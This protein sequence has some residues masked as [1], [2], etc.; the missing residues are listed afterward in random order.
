MA[1]R[2]GTCGFVY[3][4]WRGPFYPP[5]L[6]QSRWL[7]WYATRFPAVEIDASFYRLPSARAIAAWRRLTV[8]HPAFRFALKGSRLITHAR[9]LSG[10]DAAVETF[11]GRVRPLGPALAFVLWQLPPDMEADLPRLARFLDR[12]PPDLRY[13]V[14]FRHPSW[15]GPETFEVL[16]EHRVALCWVSSQRM[17]ADTTITSDFVAL[18]FH[19]LGGGFAHDYSDDE[20]RPWADALRRAAADGLDGYAFFN[21][22]GGARAPADAVQLIG[23]LGEAAAGSVVGGERLGR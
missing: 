9:R 7:A 10:A 20:L 4:H 21:N 8:E 12:L 19:G 23:L 14:E 5:G 15:L 3:D 11:L 17:P 18:R 13:A 22:D 16:R 1:I 6:P 2:V